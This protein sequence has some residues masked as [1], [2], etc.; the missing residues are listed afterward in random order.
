MLVFMW[1]GLQLAEY[2]WASDTPGGK[3]AVAYL[4]G[5]KA[6][7]LLFQRFSGG[8][9]EEHKIKLIFLLRV[10]LQLWTLVCSTT[11]ML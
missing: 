5:L 10:S 2:A 11:G 8:Q 1:F 6:I 7:S 3:D 9:E 4:S